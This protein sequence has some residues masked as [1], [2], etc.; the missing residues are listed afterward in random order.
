MFTER[1]GLGLQI[2][3][4]IFVLTVCSKGHKNFKPFETIPCPLLTLICNHV[5]VV[6]FPSSNISL[7]RSSK[8]NWMIISASTT[9]IITLDCPIPH[10]PFKIHNSLPKGI[11]WDLCRIVPPTLLSSSLGRCHSV[12]PEACRWHSASLQL[13]STVTTRH[14]QLRK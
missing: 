1:Y 5:A 2:K 10:F 13:Y 7:P 9:H 14:Q 8:Q 6:T 11:A 12:K 3:A 4:S